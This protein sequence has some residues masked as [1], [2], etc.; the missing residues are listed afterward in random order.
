MRR[1][2]SPRDLLAIDPLRTLDACAREHFP[3]DP[4]MVQWAGRYATY[5]GSSPFR[6]PATLALH[7]VPSRRE[8]GCWYP[9]GGLGAL[10]D[11]L[12]RVAHRLG[13]VTLHRQ[14]RRGRESQRRSSATASCWPAAGPSPPTWSSPTST[15]RTSTPISC[16]IARSRRRVQRAERSTSGFVVL[17]GVSRLDAGHR[18]SQRLVQRRLA[19]A[20]STQIAAG[21]LADDPTIYACVS[22]VTDPSQAPPGCENWFLLVNTPAG[23]EVDAAGYAA[24]VLDRLAR[25]RPRSPPTRCGS[26][27]R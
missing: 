25:G 4:Q 3:D 11:A 17:A 13:V 26:P 18:A 2:R 5:S 6:A 16:T 12:V 8:F 9:I 22:S 27:R 7:R 21:R 15:P 14:R 19:R 23:V 1:M 24:V 20:S 10:R